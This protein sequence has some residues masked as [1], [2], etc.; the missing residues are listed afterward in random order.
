MM[1]KSLSLSHT[2]TF[3]EFLIAFYVCRAVNELSR[4]K[5]ELNLVFKGVKLNEVAL[6]DVIDNFNIFVL[7]N[8]RHYNNAFYARVGG[9]TNAELNRLEMELLFL[10]DFE[11]TVSSRVFE[12]YC[13]Q[14]EKEMLLLNGMGQKIEKSHVMNNAI[15][16]VTEISV[17]DMQSSSPPQLMD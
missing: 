13:Q 2:H 3:L 11:M 14:L 17:E 10:L 4:V 1:C 6:T 15:D 5:L 12:S 7:V 16:D 9:V 8:V